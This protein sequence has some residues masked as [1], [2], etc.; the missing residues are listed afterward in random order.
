MKQ[1][2]RPLILVFLSALLLACNHS[3][4][5]STTKTQIHDQGV[6]IAY[7]DTGSGDTTLLFVHG[8]CINKGY[9]SNQVAYFGKKYRVVAIDLPGFGESG[10]NRKDW[11]TTAFSQDID[12]VISQLDLKNVILIGHSMA[13]DIVLQSAID[14]PKKVI[15]LVGIDNFK[16][17][18]LPDG[19]G[20]KID[21]DNAIKALKQNFKATTIEY[22]NDDLFSETTPDAVKKRVMNDVA[23]ADT[24]IAIAAMEQG[25]NF[26]EYTKLRDSKMKLYLIN[27]SVHH[28]DTSGL[29]V[30]QLPYKLFIIHGTGHF[31]MV[32][33]P[34]KFNVLLEQVIADIK[35]NKK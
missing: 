11:S 14:N 20:A 25:N 23:H 13:G 29:E 28:T 17:V 12:S 6:N 24:A 10:K 3:S 34:E 19:P 1:L 5:P 27:S 26:D 22:F 4:S 2:S 8:W 33:E 7:T 18:G 16:N 21:F 31:P 32:E 15:G 9:W 30:N 35:T